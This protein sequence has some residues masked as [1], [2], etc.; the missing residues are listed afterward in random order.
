LC[1]KYIC[2]KDSFRL[3]RSRAER[4]KDRNKAIVVTTKLQRSNTL[5][6][7]TE[8]TLKYI[9]NEALLCYAMLKCKHKMGKV[10]VTVKVIV[11]IRVRIGVG[12]S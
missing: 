9:K 2:L 4:S 5:I 10:R 12:F 7:F 1:L 11:K 8:H 6:C 3:E